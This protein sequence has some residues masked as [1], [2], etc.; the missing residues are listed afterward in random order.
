MIL[1]GDSVAM[2]VLGYDSTLPLTVDEMLHH[3]KA[4]RRGTRSAFLV[5]D[6]PYGSYHCGTED[7][8]RNAIRFVKEAGAEAVKLEG[9]ASRAPLVE[10][11]TQAEI[12]VVGHIGLTPQSLHRLGGYRVQGRSLPAIGQL[13]EDAAALEVAGAIALVLEG[14]PREVAARI[15]QAAAIPTI[16][17]GAGP[18]CDG[19]ILVFHDLFELTFLHR[20]KFVRSFGDAG[21]L[22]RQGL[23]GFRQAVTARTFPADAESY[24]LPA[25]VLAQFEPQLEPQLEPASCKS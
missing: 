24:H 17:I 5:V 19:Q 8:L 12:P 23:D 4:V 11:L 20:A 18:G 22:I 14:V 2:A 6:M 7:A 21:S 15:T 9:G 1:V 10:Q 3:A 16:G 25:E 13:L